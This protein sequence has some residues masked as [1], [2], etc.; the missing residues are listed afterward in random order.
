MRLLLLIT[1]HQMNSCHRSNLLSPADDR[2]WWRSIVGRAATE[3]NKGDARAREWLTR[4]QVGEHLETTVPHHSPGQGVLYV[5]DNGRGLSSATLG[6]GYGRRGSSFLWWGI[7]TSSAYRLEH[8]SIRASVQFATS[9]ALSR[10]ATGTWSQRENATS[11]S[12]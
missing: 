6:D 9:F 10:S 3:A 7:N 8:Y 2:L 11:E 5:L 12:S 4:Y 1:A